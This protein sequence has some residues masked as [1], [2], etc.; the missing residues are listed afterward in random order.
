[1]KFEDLKFKETAFPN[2]IQ[3]I[4][5]FANDYELSIV[6]NDM[7]Y[8]NKQGLYEIAVFKEDGQVNLPGITEEHD[9]IKGFLSKDE[10]ISIIKKMHLITGSDPVQI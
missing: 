5:K 2:G 8:G 1:M 4:L 9:T 7:S 3:S 6:R 10:V